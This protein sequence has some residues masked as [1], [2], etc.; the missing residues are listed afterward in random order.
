M[1]VTP[2][3]DL[4]GESMQHLVSRTGVSHLTLSAFSTGLKWN[5]E[6]ELR[7]DMINGLER[8][9]PITVEQIHAKWREAR[10]RWS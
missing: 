2:R 8:R 5:E 7:V 9:A 10:R 4:S 3:R 1:A 6:D